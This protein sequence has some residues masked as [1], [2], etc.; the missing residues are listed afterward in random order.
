MK[1]KTGGKLYTADNDIILPG[2]NVNLDLVEFGKNNRK[3][4][5]HNSLFVSM[6]MG[7]NNESKIEKPVPIVIRNEESTLRYALKTD[8]I[9]EDTMEMIDKKMC[10]N[11][12]YKK[13]M[14]SLEQADRFAFQRIKMSRVKI[15]AYKEDQMIG[16]L[17]KKIDDEMEKIKGMRVER[18]VWKV[19]K[20]RD[21]ENRNEEFT[22]MINKDG[23]LVETKEEIDKVLAEYNENLLSRKRHPERFRRLHEL[24][25][26]LVQNYIN[27]NDD[28]NDT[29]TEKE[30]LRALRNIYMKWKNLFK[31]SFNTSSKFKA[32]FFH[33]LKLLYDS[34]EVPEELLVTTLKPLYKKGDKRRPE[35]YRYLHLRSWMSRLYTGCHSYNLN[36][37]PCP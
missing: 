36:Y 33:V 6:K 5:D 8:E 25:K 22:S 31:P 35:N 3:Y 13:V 21:N 27:Q 17:Q 19:S 15:Q 7:R 20:A 9:T 16:S 10:M 23:K 26:S 37:R 14:R 12:I 1:Y 11:D 4:S 24:K 34:E 32:A 18:Q 29:L 30:Y 2:G 28:N